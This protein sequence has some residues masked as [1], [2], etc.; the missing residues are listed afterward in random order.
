MES[1]ERLLDLI[2][3]VAQGLFH[4]MRRV[5]RER[6]MPGSFMAIMRCATQEPGVTITELARRSGM[7]KSHV[8]TAVDELCRRGLVE[9]R[10]DDHDRRLQHLY[11]TPYAREF[12][13]EVR[14]EARERLRGVLSVLSE[15]QTNSLIMDLELLRQAL[16]PSQGDLKGPGPPC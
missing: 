9:R 14:T 6:G 3:S 12:F 5:A 1:D 11:P 16:H 7:A 15:E 4:E 10:G 8:S 2:H 13:G